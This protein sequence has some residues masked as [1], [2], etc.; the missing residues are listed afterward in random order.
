MGSRV[1]SG[2]LLI[3]FSLGLCGCV[4]ATLWEKKAFDGFNEPAHP[5]NLQVSR[6]TND[7]LIQYDEVSEDFGRIRRRAY[8]LYA[9]DEKVRGHKQPDF[10]KRPVATSGAVRAVISDSRGEFTVYDG[11]LLVGTYELPVYPKPS[12]RAKQ[13]LLTPFTVVADAAIVGAGS[14]LFVAYLWAKSGAPWPD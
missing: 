10:V 11:D 5:A 4:T 6:Y 7:W 1:Y 13:I 12:G 9:N 3:A 14:A 2:I 8:F